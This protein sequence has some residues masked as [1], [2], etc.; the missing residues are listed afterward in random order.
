MVVGIHDLEGEKAQVI[1]MNKQLLS[2]R[3]RVGAEIVGIDQATGAIQEEFQKVDQMEGVSDEQKAE[4]KKSLQQNLD[5]LQE[6]KVAL[7]EEL[8]RIDS[9]IAMGEEYSEE[10]DKGIRE[11]Q[12]AERKMRLELLSQIDQYQEELRRAEQETKKIAEL[13][14]SAEADVVKS[15]A[16]MNAETNERLKQDYASVI[17]SAQSRVALYAQ[18]AQKQQGLIGSVCEFLE[19]EASDLVHV[20]SGAEGI[21]LRVK[22]EA[23]KGYEDF[24]ELARKSSEDLL[25]NTGQN[26]DELHER[27]SEGNM[28]EDEG[29][30]WKKIWHKVKDKRLA[31]DAYQKDI[32]DMTAGWENPQSNDQVG[33]ALWEVAKKLKAKPA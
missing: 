22:E 23:I 18:L 21:D 4:N 27:V 24:V 15:E 12:D 13:Q 3:A 6:E 14:K 31:P 1:E 25:K 28:S 26:F 5:R 16:L 9:R 11:I 10:L 30:L 20:E 7:T 32:A 33:W 2:E 19:K 17:Q 8:K 29:G